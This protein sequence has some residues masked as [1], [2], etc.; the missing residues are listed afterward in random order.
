MRKAKTACSVCRWRRLD[1]KVVH[2]APAPVFPRLV[3][4]DY[5]VI[6]RVKV[7]RC[8]LALGLVAAADVS[9]GKAHP[10][11][12]P[13]RSHFQALLAPVRRPGIDVLNLVEMRALYTGHFLP[14]SRDSDG[15]SEN[16]LG[17][18]AIAKW[19]A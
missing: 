8:V 14:L 16:W 18:H 6:A 2:I 10:E 1:K 5:R 17:Y 11:M 19:G 4:L 7:L 12:H 13:A 15:D 9:T 3:T